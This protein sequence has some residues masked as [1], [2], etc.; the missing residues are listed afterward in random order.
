MMFQRARKVY[1]R[2]SPDV[3]ASSVLSQKG[4][5][6]FKR[7]AVICRLLKMF[8]SCVIDKKNCISLV[9]RSKRQASEAQRNSRSGIAAAKR[10]DAEAGM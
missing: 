3:A 7:N 4:T 9:S 8:I 5:L 2:G 10:D 6:S 1:R